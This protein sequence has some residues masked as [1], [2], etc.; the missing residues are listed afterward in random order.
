MLE[1]CLRGAWSTDGRH[2]TAIAEAPWNNAR[3]TNE[4]DY[5]SGEDAGPARRY[6]PHE[7]TPYAA[8]VA[9]DGRRLGCHTSAHAVLARE[10]SHTVGATSDEDNS[11]L[12]E[13]CW[14]PHII[15]HHQG[16]F[17]VH[18]TSVWTTLQM[19]TAQGNSNVAPVGCSN[20]WSTLC[21]LSL[22]FDAE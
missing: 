4:G 13:I 3:Q 14:L 8:T 2:T 6:E 10:E 12:P 9:S 21:R 20:A 15:L 16:Q 7:D 17:H 1:P 22:Y 18:F 11:A 19:C 5:Y